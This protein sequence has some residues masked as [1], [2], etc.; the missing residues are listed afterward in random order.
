MTATWDW[1]RNQP[2]WILPNGQGAGEF[3]DKYYV[4]LG[5]NLQRVICRFGWLF[6]YTQEVASPGAT[7]APGDVVQ[8]VSVG[9]DSG[10]EDVLFNVRAAVLATHEDRALSGASWSTT[11]TSS[12]VPIDLHVTIWRTNVLSH[13]DQ[14]WVKLHQ[15]VVF[16][17]TTLSVLP[18]GQG[19]G[20]LDFLGSTPGP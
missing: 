4:P 1:H 2:G 16:Y 11:Y 5:Q 8:R 20:Q 17:S 14:L 13:E 3:E 10:E 9:R 18:A 19:S 7:V 15:D 6:L 12:T